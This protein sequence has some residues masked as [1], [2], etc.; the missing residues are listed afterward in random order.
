L[1][2]FETEFRTHYGQ[3]SSCKRL[4]NYRKGLRSSCLGWLLLTV[5][6]TDSSIRQHKRI[7]YINSYFCV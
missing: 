2:L 3:Q 6:T 7:L 5:H 1:A 4:I